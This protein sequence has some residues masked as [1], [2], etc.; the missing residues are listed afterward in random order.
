MAIIFYQMLQLP[1]RLKNTT[2]DVKG[3]STLDEDILHDI[4]Y[5]LKKGFIVK[6]DADVK[7]ITAHTILTLMDVNWN[8][9]H[10]SKF[11]LWNKKG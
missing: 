3:I 10:I 9:L 5:L 2:T 4:R 1:L 7:E 11:E 6:S 8:N